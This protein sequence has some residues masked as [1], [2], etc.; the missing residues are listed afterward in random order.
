MPKRKRK[1]PAAT[2]A[3]RGGPVDG[4]LAKALSHPTRAEILAFLA[5]H[6]VG[7]PREMEKAG[8]GK[9]G[10]NRGGKGRKLAHISYHVDVLSDLRLIV[11]V[12]TEPVRGATQHFYAANA[13]MLLSVEDWSKLPRSS[14]TDVSIAALEEVFSLARKALSEDTFD[15]F[16]E[17]AV[18]NQTFRLDDR[19]FVQLCDEMTEFALQRCQQLQAESIADVEGN[20]GQLKYFS[21]SMLAYESPPPKRPK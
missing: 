20:L 15:S 5:E 19:R 9:K 8:L 10:E 3:A 12:K 11:L 21:T 6:E 7:S 1:K 17:R 4:V 2:V 13:R 16:N 18:I 14:K